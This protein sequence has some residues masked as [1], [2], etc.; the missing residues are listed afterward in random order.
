MA[1]RGGAKPILL[2]SEP[3]AL[4]GD[5][6][7]TFPVRNP[8][9]QWVRW[10]DEVYC[11]IISQDELAPADWRWHVSVSRERDY[12]S[13]DVPVWRDLRDL[14]WWARPGV[15]FA[16]PLPPKTLWMNE[17]PNVLHAIEIRD[18]VL[19]DSWRLTHENAALLGSTVPS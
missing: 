10:K 17:N 14:V 18:A 1:K 8:I 15:M 3:W 2:Q 12:G 4:P 16:V 6:E 5:L 7:P 13:D 19:E 9:R 11:M